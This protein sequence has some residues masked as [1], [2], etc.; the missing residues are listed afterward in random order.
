MCP[1][2]KIAINLLQ[3]SVGFCEFGLSENRAAFGV[4]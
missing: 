2:Y 1:G 3:K 4:I